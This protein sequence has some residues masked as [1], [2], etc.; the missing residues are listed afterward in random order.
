MHDVNLLKLNSKKQ[1]QKQKH[2]SLG[3][4]TAISVL[5]FR[6]LRGLAKR[7]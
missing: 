7:S 3:V 1:A 6:Q 2:N 5:L 4:D